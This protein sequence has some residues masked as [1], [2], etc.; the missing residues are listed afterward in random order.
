[1]NSY[2]ITQ[3]VP[4]DVVY[5]DIAWYG[6]TWSLEGVGLPDIF[7]LTYVFEFKY[8]HYFHD[9]TNGVNPSVDVSKKVISASCKVM[10]ATYRMT[11]HNVFGYGTNKIYDSSKMVLI[12]EKHTK[13]YPQLLED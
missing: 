7:P 12:T 1:M 9:L 13:L 8:T 2:D 4:G 11:T 6:N 10:R 5:V 3:V